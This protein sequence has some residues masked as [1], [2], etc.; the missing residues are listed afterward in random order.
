MI[1][2]L[3]GGFIVSTSLAISLHASKIQEEKK[4]KS[5]EGRKLGNSRT[6]PA[7]AN[8]WQKEQQY[9]FK[10]EVGLVQKVKQKRYQLVMVV[11]K[12]QSVS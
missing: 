2:L 4:V 12:F 8:Q 9:S 10:Y 7:E 11:S 5:K 6:I 1:E 3:K